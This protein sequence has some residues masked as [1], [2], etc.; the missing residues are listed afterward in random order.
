MPA[1][2]D[3]R[4]FLQLVLV[5]GMIPALGGC[6]AAAIPVIAGAL[7]AKKQVDG[8]SSKSRNTAASNPPV[9]KRVAVF[10]GESSAKA[11]L[12]PTTLYGAKPSATPAAKPVELVPVAV[13]DVVVSAAPKSSD[14]LAVVAPLT[15]PPAPTLVQPKLA[16]LPVISAAPAIK[17]MAKVETAPQAAIAKPK[18]KPTLSAP[19]APLSSKSSGYLGLTAYAISRANSP[20]AD[21]VLDVIDPNDPLGE[22]RRPQCGGLAPAVVI[23]L[24][25]ALD[26]FNPGAATAQP[27]L[28]DALAALRA[29]GITVMW[30]SALPVELA[31][32]VHAALARTGLDPSR[33]DR[34]LLLKGA[35]DRKQARRLGA[36]RN[37]CVI[38]MAGDRRGDFDE[39]F[40]Y[41]R[42][43]DT[44]IPADALFGAG[45]FLAPPPIP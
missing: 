14:G 8:G 28:G 21:A 27:G 3:Q 31:E 7:V 18:P 11:T 4:R 6:V 16:E 36:A 24:D 45:W 13:P 25:P 32:K 5:L 20:E 22:P 37:W 1:R 33:T 12:A 15:T 38:A 35:G 42:D 41:L 9:E 34:L 2:S 19:P 44:R 10:V 23:D 26:A 40:D 17:P 29:A 43:P 30:S 39:V